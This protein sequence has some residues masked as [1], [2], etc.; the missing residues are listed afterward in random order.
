MIARRRFSPRIWL[1]LAACALLLVTGCEKDEE[2]PAAPP[3]VQSDNHYRLYSLTSG[4]FAR[5]IAM[6]DIPADTLLRQL[7]IPGPYA[8]LAL[9]PSNAHL[10]VSAP[11]FDSTLLV[12]ADS[13]KIR[14]TLLFGG[15]YLVDRTRAVT[16]LIG[17][18]ALFRIN[19]TS[20]SRGDSINLSLRYAQIDTSSGQLYGVGNPPR[21]PSVIYRIDYLTMSLVDS[22][23]AR[24]PD[25]SLITVTDLL[26]LSNLNRLYFYGLVGTQA[27]AFIW[28]LQ[29]GVVVSS[30]GHDYPIGS[31]TRLIGNQTVLKADP[32]PLTT[33][34]SG[35]LWIYSIAGDAI[36]GSYSTV[37]SD[38]GTVLTIN[39]TNVLQTP[40][41]AY[42]YIAGGTP[43]RVLRLP[44]ATGSVTNVF[45]PL[46]SFFPPEIVLGPLIPPA[47]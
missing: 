46:S 21:N 13:L 8:V 44:L 29:A 18:S 36:T 3:P 37:V 7:E 32:G 39:A 34:G 12:D 15:R 16:L 6:H 30:V 42:L 23:T 28:D 5:G 17:S 38:N 31:F 9:T 40:D 11:G 47:D 1:T 41:G 35:K 27:S 4:F 22:I 2:G 24:D 19:T 45:D 14:D 25:D 26:P 10:L 43:G 20:F 33:P